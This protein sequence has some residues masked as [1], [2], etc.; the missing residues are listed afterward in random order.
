MLGG[1][2]RPRRRSPG[3]LLSGRRLSATVVVFCL[4]VVSLHLLVWLVVQKGYLVSPRLLLTQ[5]VGSLIG[6]LGIHAEVRDATIFLKRETWLMSTECTGIFP[7]LTFASF[8]LAYPSRLK[9][10]LL[11]FLIGIPTIFAANILRLVVLACLVELKP[12]YGSYFHDYLWQVAFI[13][14]IVILWLVWIEG[15]VKGERKAAVSV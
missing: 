13:L 5:V 8:V 2:R 7:V 9:A 11:G 10:K 4:L 1:R 14:L 12:A 15:V 3:F 6:A